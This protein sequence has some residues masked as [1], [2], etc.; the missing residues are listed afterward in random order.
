MLT[1]FGRCTPPIQADGEPVPPHPTLSLASTPATNPRGPRHQPQPLFAP[2]PS[3]RHRRVV[4]LP[5]STSCR[6]EVT[7]RRVSSSTWPG[8]RLSPRCRA[9]A[10]VRLQTLDFLRALD[11]LLESVKSE[12]FIARRDSSRGWPPTPRW[13]APSRR[14]FASTEPG[15]QDVSRGAVGRKPVRSLTRVKSLW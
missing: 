3:P 13:K 12:Y 1:T 7:R 15:N 14:R 4:L 2:T 10:A 6:A 8:F 5:L 11:S 9:V